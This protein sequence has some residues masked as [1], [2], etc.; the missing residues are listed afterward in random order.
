MAVVAR[1]E[2]LLSLRTH[3]FAT[4]RKDGPPGLTELAVRG[5]RSVVNGRFS[6]LAICRRPG[7]G[8]C[9]GLSWVAGWGDPAWGA[10]LAK[11]RGVQEQLR[12][13][14][15]S[16]PIVLAPYSVIRVFEGAELV[17]RVFVEDVDHPSP[18]ETKIRPVSE[19]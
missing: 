8:M 12:C 3:A 9:P 17:G 18:V 15:V 1:M 19:S 4:A 5:I 6:L 13:V 2:V 16:R 11:V 7:R 14:L 10:R